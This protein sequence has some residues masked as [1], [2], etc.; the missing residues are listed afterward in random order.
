MAVGQFIH[1]FGLGVSRLKVN[2]QMDFVKWIWENG[3]PQNAECK[4]RNAEPGESQSERRRRKDA[5][6]W[7]RSP[8]RMQKGIRVGKDA[9]RPRAVTNGIAETRR[10]Q[11]FAWDSNGEG[12]SSSAASPDGSSVVV[13][14]MPL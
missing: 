9:K 2:C 12:A 10:T 8:S 3:R 6:D 7:R 5:K 4:V 1:Y 13:F 14:C 11:G